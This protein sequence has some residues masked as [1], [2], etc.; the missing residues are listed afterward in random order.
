MVKK[1]QMNCTQFYL[2]TFCIGGQYTMYLTSFFTVV[3]KIDTMAFQLLVMEIF[4]F[5]YDYNFQWILH[6]LN[7]QG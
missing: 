3:G 7:A 1:T 4:F 2:K 5:F 6:I